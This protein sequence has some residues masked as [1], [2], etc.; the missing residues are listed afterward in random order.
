MPG[1][2]D[3][4]GRPTH[5]RAVDLDRFF[6][7]KAVAVVG[8]S[9]TEGKPNTGITR[10]LRAW[11]DRV[12]ATLYPVN[13]GRESVDGR[14]C[15]PSVTDIEGDVDVAALLVGDPVAALGPVVEKKIAFAVIFA[16]GFAEVGEDGAAAQERLLATV[17][18]TDT[19]ILGPNTNLNA[20]EVFRDDL[21][22]PSI[23]LISQSGHQGRPIFQS[24]ELGIRVSHWAPTGNEVDLEFADFA[25]YFSDQPEVGVIA[26]YVEGF[27]D[28]RTLL[29]AADHA[30][31]RGVPI[32]AV[33]VGR[34]DE[35]R[36][37]ASSHTGKL[38]GADA[39][40]TAAMKQ[41]GVTRV[42]ELDELLDVSQLLARAK[43]PT[44]DGVVVY[45]ISGGT[46]AHMA[47][48]VAEA[49]LRMPQL[50]ETTQE[51]LYEWI[52]R[53]LRVS[54][55]VD[56]GGH[57]VG[58][59]RGRKILDTLLADPDVGA[60]VCPITGAFP[61]MSDK[62]AQDLV[63]VAET[64]NKP[65]C[66]IWGSPVGTESA[67]RDILLSSR[68]IAVFRTFGNCVTALRAWVDWHA[69]LARRQSPF[70]GLAPNAPRA[71]ASELLRKPA[72]SEWDSKQLLAS[73]GIAAPNE[74]LVMTAADAVAA[75][76]EIGY[77]VV[78]KGCG[79]HL[80]HKS[81]LGVVRVGLTD[82]DALRTAYDEIMTK[83]GDMDGVIVAEMVSGGVEA[84]VGL[85]Y[86]ELFGPVVMAGL[87]GVFV[88]VF[89]DVAFRVPPF[90]ADEARRM[91]GELRGLPLLQG[92]RGNPPVD[93]DALVDVIVRVQQ[94][95]L[96]LG[97]ELRELDINPLFVR[98]SGAVALDA[99]AIP[100]GTR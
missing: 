66:V 98:P 49:G 6:H 76:D 71:V 85:S 89:R 1:R 2:V 95:A 24:Q 27:K 62:L 53:Y 23:A 30:A 4:G 91:V 69:F 25:A 93:I 55:P 79:A 5:L 65:V 37:M 40:I 19:R 16:S 45:A 70:A 80:A 60:L 84:V 21:D 33:K 52:P 22:G 42:R 28:G 18:G 44:T 43:A 75:A 20:F 7:P 35:G 8:A 86:D 38:T 63:D 99:L 94:M 100:R 39:V 50:S 10:Q 29:L 14:R 11:A 51:Q 36:S 87:G 74:R 13:P 73:Y 57:P 15:Y 12:G 56:N 78:L 32:V 41:Y 83:S 34:T 82:A 61:P 31:E 68:K 88:E 47:D 90:D 77:P 92:A 81:E 3:T 26:A 59:W 58:D 46:G 17:A 64:T 9:D 48:L 67:Y 72:L 54:N 97:D 96:E